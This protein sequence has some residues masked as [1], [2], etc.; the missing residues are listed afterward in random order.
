MARVAARPRTKRR[1]APLSLGKFK[2]QQRMRQHA[3]DITS[4]TDSD[5]V[6]LKSMKPPIF[7]SPRATPMRRVTRKPVLPRKRCSLVREYAEQFAAL[8]R[9][10]SACPSASQGG[11]LGQITAGQTTPEFERALLAL[12]P[13]S[14][15]PEPVAT[16]YGFHIVRL[17]RKHEG[18]DLPFELVAVRIAAYLQDCVQRRAL[19]QY[20]A[21]LASAARI[22][23]IDLAGA[24]ALR[25]SG[26][27]ACYSAIS[28][29]PS[30]TK[31]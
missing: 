6:H 22:D 4:R 11:N 5:S 15:G 24:E 12:E 27:R 14:I 19:A 25:V 10:H 1:F 30:R 7:Y 20:V 9:A 3:G 8:A 23:G 2:R 21:R 26:T 16:S 28:L 18:R 17:D 29:A 13:G 31:P